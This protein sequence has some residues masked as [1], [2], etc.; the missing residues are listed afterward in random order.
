[1]S[2]PP[3]DPNFTVAMLHEAANKFRDAGYEYWVA[4]H[5][6]GLTG[7]AVIWTASDSGY[8]ALFTRGEYRTT[9]LKNIE[10]LGYSIEFGA[11]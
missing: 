8:M 3:L 11:A 9:I 7:G 5:K 10:P 1:M 6:S 2:I 4:C